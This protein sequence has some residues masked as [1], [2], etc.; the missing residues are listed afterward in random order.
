MSGKSS[1][2]KIIG[3]IS[4]DFRLDITDFG[5]K[6]EIKGNKEKSRESDQ[7]KTAM[8]GWQVCILSVVVTKFSLYYAIASHQGS[9]RL[10]PSQNVTS[11]HLIVYLILSRYMFREVIGLVAR[12]ALLLPTLSPASSTFATSP[13]HDSIQARSAEVYPRIWIAL[14]GTPVQDAARAS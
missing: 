9:F 7:G 12:T 6:C 5:K 14:A 4:C 2:C 13:A 3:R 10:A 1:P 8:G 11:Q